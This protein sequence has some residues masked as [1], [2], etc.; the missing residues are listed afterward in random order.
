MIDKPFGDHG[1]EDDDVIEEGGVGVFD[2]E[3]SSR[4]LSR[5]CT[6]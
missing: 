3:R 5:L 6:L 2:V 1:A 4:R